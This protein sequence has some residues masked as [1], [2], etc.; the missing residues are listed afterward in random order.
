MRKCNVMYIGSSNVFN[1]LM[2]ALYI[3]HPH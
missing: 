2:P 3:T 1:H